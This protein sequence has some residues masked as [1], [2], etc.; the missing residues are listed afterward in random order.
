MSQF[1]RSIDR[2]IGL[3]GCD[4]QRPASQP[5]SCQQCPCLPKIKTNGRLDP[6]GTARLPSL[7]LARTERAIACVC[8]VW[9]QFRRFVV[10]GRCSF[11]ACALLVPKARREEVLHP[12][13]SSLMAALRATIVGGGAACARGPGRHHASKPTAPPASPPPLLEMFERASSPFGL[14]LG[15]LGGRPPL[16]P[17]GAATGVHTRL[18]HGRWRGSLCGRWHVFDPGRTGH[19]SG[20]TKNSE[21]GRPQRQEAPPRIFS[22]PLATTNHGHAAAPAPHRRRGLQGEHH[23]QAARAC[24]GDGGRAGRR[25][26]ATRRAKKAAPSLSVRRPRTFRW[27]GGSGWRKA[28]APRRRLRRRQ[29]AIHGQQCRPTAGVERCGW[30]ARG[31]WSLLRPPV[32]SWGAGGPKLFADPA[33]GGP[34]RGGTG[35]G[36]KGRHRTTTR[37]RVVP[38]RCRCPLPLLNC[39]GRNRRRRGLT[40]RLTPQMSTHHTHTTTKGNPPYLQTTSQ[41]QPCVRSCTCRAASAATRSAPSSGR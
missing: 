17:C 15:P 25:A 27:A 22:T 3:L 5:Q 40:H 19:T 12:L 39:L 20:R 10:F 8:G 2:S 11:G 18:T 7:A 21:R 4:F 31:W 26:A 24:G 1:D 34:G 37:G 14:P 23:R 35:S 41:Q 16:D 33:S 38:P 6:F 32:A 28:A 9:W 13:R 36:S 30:R 29:G